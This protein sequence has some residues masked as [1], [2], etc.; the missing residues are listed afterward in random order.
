MYFVIYY[1]RYIN[2]ENIIE[3]KIVKV[4]ENLQNKFT[5]GP[6]N[7]TS[8]MIKDFAFVKPFQVRNPNTQASTITELY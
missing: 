4:S 7:I 1:N 5:A 3:E 2:F 6:E 8:F